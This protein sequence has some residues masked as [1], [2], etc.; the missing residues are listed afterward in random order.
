MS[1]RRDSRKSHLRLSQVSA[2]TNRLGEDTS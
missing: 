2:R 1:E